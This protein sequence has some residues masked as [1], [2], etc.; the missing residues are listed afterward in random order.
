[1]YA[2]VDCNSFYASCER[3]FDPR[4]AHRPVIVLSNNDGCVVTASTEAK[5][6]GISIGVPFFEIQPLVQTHNI[7]VRSSNYT[8]YADLSMRVMAILAG[9]APEL[10][11]YSID[12]AF[13]DLRGIRDDLA[14]YGRAIR[15]KILQWTGI[16]VSVGIAPTKT[17]AKV[18]NHLAK[19]SATAGGVE[20]LTDPARQE[21]VLAALKPQDIWGIGGRLTKRL[22]RVGIT[23]ALQLRDA[24]S[25]LVRSVLT[26]VGQRT[27]LE[28]RGIACLPMELAPP[29]SKSIVRSRSFGKPVTTIEQLEEA[30][31]MHTT[32]AAEKLRQQK[33]VASAMQ[34]FL[35]TNRFRSDQRQYS[36][37]ATVR[38]DP[39][40]DDTG[41]LL[42]YAMEAIRRIFREGFRFKSAGVMLND[43]SPRKG[44]Q[45]KLFTKVDRDRSKRL[46]AALDSVNARLGR[47]TLRYASSGFT[48]D[49]RMKQMH[50]SPFCTTRW[51]QL[52]VVHCR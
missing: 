19:H 31:S 21:E 10:E 26:V 20:V 37:A 27:A 45:M 41:V 52:P 47:D 23:N 22:R 24:D 12:E 50:R 18:A 17:L 48:R 40:S 25:K 46:M 42:G 6:L 14:E 35:M 7:A 16:P 1:M 36:N 11:I 33:L 8:L 38:I 49:W 4:L 3:V 28:L 32:R 39:P 29:H 5:A 34:V 51:D 43:L 30:V 2:L 15:R 9:F 44:V 13:L